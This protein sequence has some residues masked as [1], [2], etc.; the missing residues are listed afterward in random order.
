MPQPYFVPVSP[1]S[2]R[3]TQSNGVS[4]SMSKEWDTP[5]MER[6]IAMERFL[7]RGL[8]C[9]PLCKLW[10]RAKI[11][12]SVSINRLCKDLKPANQTISNQR[13]ICF[14]PPLRRA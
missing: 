12:N 7:F 8:L 13:R 3:K 2:S 10:P 9:G 14:T 11:G 6:L 5:L 4:G 1:I